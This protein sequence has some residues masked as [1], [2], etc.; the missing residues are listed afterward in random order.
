MNERMQFGEYERYA[1]MYAVIHATPECPTASLAVIGW[2]GLLCGGGQRMITSIHDNHNVCV[3]TYYYI[4]M[5]THTHVYAYTH[6][7]CFARYVCVCACVCVV[8]HSTY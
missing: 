6:F 5:H 7:W 4:H 8:T 2:T 3:M 1:N